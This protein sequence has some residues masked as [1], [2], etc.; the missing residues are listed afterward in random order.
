MRGN[1][2]IGSYLLES[3]RRILAL[4]QEVRAHGGDPTQVA[5]RFSNRPGIV[6]EV[7]YTREYASDI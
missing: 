5:A 4:V 6:N 2:D 1:S 3:R 7:A